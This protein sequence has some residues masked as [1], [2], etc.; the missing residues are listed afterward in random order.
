MATGL[1]QVLQHLQQAGGG[2]T[3]GQL[4]ARFTA[5]RDE[6][7]F[8]ALVERHGPM[9]LGVCRRVL[10]NRPDAEDAFQAAFFALTRHAASVRKAGS[11]AAWLYGAALRVALK[12]RKSA[13]RTPDPARL[14]GRTPIADPLAEITARELVAVIDAELARLPDTLRAPIVLC[15]LEGL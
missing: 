12:V 14:A 3:D 15:C 13:S 1:G 6:A 7:A 11:L 2:P 5:T 9:V 10:G 4:L 8:A